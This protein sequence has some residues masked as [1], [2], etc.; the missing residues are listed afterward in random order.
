MGTITIGLRGHQ[1]VQELQP[2]YSGGRKSRE[3]L[4]RLRAYQ[5]VLLLE[6]GNLAFALLLVFLDSLVDTFTEGV[7][8][9]FP[10]LLLFQAILKNVHADDDKLVLVGEWP[11]R[12]STAVSGAGCGGH[13]KGVGNPGTV[14]S[15]VCGTQTPGLMWFIW[16]MKKS[17]AQ[18]ARTE[19][20]VQCVFGVSPPSA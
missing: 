3:G 15:T 20:W 1:R 17:K 9:Y 10:L 11:L 18:R 2:L 8:L 14:R 6:L 7:K 4:R 12:K 5:Q 13:G 16:W 19:M